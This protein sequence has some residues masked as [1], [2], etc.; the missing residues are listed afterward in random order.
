MQYPIYCAHM[1]S[2][3]DEKLVFRTSSNQV[4]TFHSNIELIL[5][6][7]QA[8]TGIF[9][10]NVIAQAVSRKL[11][12]SPALAGDAID[13]LI[14]CKILSNSCEQISMYHPLTYNPPQY[15]PA[16]SA[17]EI[18]EL[19][20]ARPDYSAKKTAAVYT[21]Q[22]PLTLSVCELLEKRHSCRAFQDMPVEKESLFALCRASYSH[23]LSPVA[24]AGGLFPLSIYFINRRPSELPAGLY[25]YHPKKETLL[26]LT[27]ELIP[28]ALQYALNDEDMVFNAPCIFFICGDIGRHIKKYGNRGYR[29]TLLE[30]G[31]AVQN[32]TLAA[33]ELGLSGVEYGGFCD[34]AVMRLFQLPEEVFPLAC[35]AAG[36]EDKEPGNAERFQ[37]N[38]QERRILEQISCGEELAVHPR[39]ASSK[40]LALSNLRVMVSAFKDAAGRLEFGTGAAAAYGG[41]YV[42]S[43][44]EAYERYTIS[45]RYA[46]FIE[47][48]DRLDGPYLDPE[49]YAPYSDKQLL[50]AGFSKFKK[51]APSEWL[52]GYRLDGSPLYVPADLCFDAASP[53]YPPCHIANTSGCAAGFDVAA[54]ERAALLELIERDAIVRT[55]LYRQPPRR[56]REDSLPDHIRQRLGRYKE[57]GVSL[58]VLLLPC[59][60]AYAV[61]VCSASVSSPPYFVSGAAASFASVLEAVIKA[62][63]EWEV[64]F[65]LGD[66]ETASNIIPPDQVNSPV[67]HGNLYRWADHNDQIAYLLH[68]PQINVHDIPT[69]SLRNIQELSP[70][71]C[72]Y[73]PLVDHAYVVRAFSEELVPIN[74]GYGMDF[75]KHRKIDGGLLKQSKFPHFFA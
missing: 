55:W 3:S 60:Y 7:L 19:T 50:A 11:E 48:A 15:P 70:A 69:N 6:I 64:S 61:L 31:H 40:R 65:V 20:A 59:A 27:D 54:A 49:V 17:K 16:V 8:S 38:E 39:L 34:E 41:A 45:R 24:S 32:M 29:Y 74:F 47:R 26:L 30:A 68:G 46:D 23:R 42:R 37:R 14:A 44:M 62:F 13:D 75:W 35:Y 51:D 71:F 22:A 21:D 9:P 4:C 33:T 2:Q 67:D 18:D 28:E 36:Y 66:S 1:L 5:A 63:Q 56:L 58:F 25:Q 12:I 10:A 43:V 72:L 53:N 57:Q 52:Q 73:K